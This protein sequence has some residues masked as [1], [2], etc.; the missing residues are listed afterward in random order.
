MRSTFAFRKAVSNVL[1]EFYKFMNDWLSKNEPEMDTEV[2][3]VPLIE[4][5]GAFVNKFTGIYTASSE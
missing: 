4:N 1:E 5:W 2:G 3:E